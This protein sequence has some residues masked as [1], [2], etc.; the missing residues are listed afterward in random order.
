VRC[1][2]A[3]HHPHSI[4]VLSESLSCLSKFRDLARN[5]GEWFDAITGAVEYVE[6]WF[7]Q[8]DDDLVQR[9]DAHGG[10]VVDIDRDGLLDLYVAQG[11][12]RGTDMTEHSENGLFWGTAD[13][14]LVGGRA[15]AK[16]A[17][18]DCRGCRAYNVGML[19]V[20]NDGLLDILSLNMERSDKNEIPSRL[21]FNRPTA[22]E[23]RHFTFAPEVAVYANGAIMTDLD[24]ATASF[25]CRLLPRLLNTVSC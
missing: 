3:F 15:A 20:D 11:T 10:A 19:D 2:A 7:E 17:G 16:S 4:A 18:L 21:W 8:P 6:G 13:G 23:P 22:G 9:F 1:A 14:K 24:Q 12:S 5:N 25:R